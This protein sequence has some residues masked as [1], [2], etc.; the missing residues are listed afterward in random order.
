[1]RIEGLTA[2]A[3]RQ[4]A[5]RASLRAHFAHLWEGI[6]ALIAQAKA[7]ISLAATTLTRALATPSVPVVTR[8]SPL[9]D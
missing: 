5:L 3:E 8:A 2:Y 4:A 6:P 9:T 1:M 7:D